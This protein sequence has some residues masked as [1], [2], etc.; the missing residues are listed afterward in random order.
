MK[1]YYDLTS[2]KKGIPLY[3]KEESPLIAAVCSRIIYFL[4]R[5]ELDVR[6]EDRLD[7]LR[8]TDDELRLLELEE[9]ILLREEDEELRDGAEYRDEEELRGEE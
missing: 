3:I 6:D 5:L 8:L 1:N 4:R 2:S 9:V 7:E